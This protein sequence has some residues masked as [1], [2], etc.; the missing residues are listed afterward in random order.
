[1]AKIIRAAKCALSIRETGRQDFWWRWV[2][3][4]H[5]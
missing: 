3:Y 5:L 4:H 2:H 1:M